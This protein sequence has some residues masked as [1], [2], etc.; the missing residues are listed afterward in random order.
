MEE[1]ENTSNCALRPMSISRTVAAVT[2][3]PTPKKININPG[4][5]SSNNIKIAPNTNQ[6]TSAVNKFKL[7]SMKLKVKKKP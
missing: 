6:T 1:I 4:A 2:H 3:A 7:E 5:S